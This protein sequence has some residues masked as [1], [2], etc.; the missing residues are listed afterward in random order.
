MAG[1]F[2]KRAP[3]FTLLEILV[4]LVIFSVSLALTIPFI[5]KGGRSVELKAAAKKLG[6]AFVHARALAVRE[7]KNY[8]VELKDGRVLITLAGEE[9]RAKE[10]GFSGKVRI[11]G[12]AEKIFFYPGGGS[13]GGEYLLGNDGAPKLRVKVHS[14]GRVTVR[15]HD[16]SV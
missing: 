12:S 10:I 6:S 11:E 16:E 15:K 3:G 14:S 5:S 8:C 9:G 1:L 13:S 4:V 2:S 7:R